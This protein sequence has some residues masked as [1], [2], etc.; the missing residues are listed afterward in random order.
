MS[1]VT[2]NLRNQLDLARSRYND[3][4]NAVPQP[5]TT[6]T[7]VGVAGELYQVR[8]N[9]GSGRIYTCRS[10]S[11]GAIEID[12]NGQGKPVALNTTDQGT[13]T[14]SVMPN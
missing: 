6:G 2:A 11:T 7:V 12:A 13:P 8:A 4:A 5:P 3:R 9:D 10:I 1:D 14:I